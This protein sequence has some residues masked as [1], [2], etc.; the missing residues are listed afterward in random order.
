MLLI[1][2]RGVGGLLSLII[3]GTATPALAATVT[4][5]PVV[6]G[7]AL[8][9]TGVIASMATAASRSARSGRGDAVRRR[10]GHEGATP[11]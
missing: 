8:F 7:V 2:G 4:T 5:D 9:L 1:A 6:V 3:R 10:F 11:A